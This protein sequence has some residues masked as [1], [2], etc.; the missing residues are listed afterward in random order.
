MT[1]RMIWGPGPYPSGSK[2]LGI[3]RHPVDGAQGVAIWMPTGIMVHG[4]AGVV[5]SM[6]QTKAAAALGSIK[7]KRKSRTSRENGKKGGRPKKY[8]GQ[9]TARLRH[10]PCTGCGSI[11]FR[12]MTH[13]G[14]EI[15]RDKETGRLHACK[16]GRTRKP[17]TNPPRAR[18]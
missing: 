9:S 8:L 11:V 12:V 2:T 6:P 14:E 3:I 1:E 7:S 17:T 15:L 16:G 10:F 18:R 5:R 4:A 13:T